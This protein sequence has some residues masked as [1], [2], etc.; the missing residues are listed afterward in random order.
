MDGIGINPVA[1]QTVPQPKA[2]QAP[3]LPKPAQSAPQTL[4][5]D[6]DA[7][8]AEQR[9][10]E[11]VQKAARSVAND[12][13]VSDTRFTIYKGADGQYITR[14]T[15]LISGQVTYIPEPDLLSKSGNSAATQALNIE[16]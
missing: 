7:K 14:F 11:A 6:F 5:V 9:R 8:E 15:S 1:L 2:R 4:Q 16:V 10:F 3:V 12:Y 13:V